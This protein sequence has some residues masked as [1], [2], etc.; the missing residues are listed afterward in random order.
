MATKKTL[1]KTTAKATAPI[2]AA[3]IVS[4]PVASKSGK[5]AKKITAEERY[6]MIQEAA[7]YIA[8][9][10]AFISNPA[11]DWAAAEAEI[12]AKLRLAGRI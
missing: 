10:K 12:D 3:K 4:A 9:S 5:T 2:A 8:E 6:K 11:E 7:Y 1:N